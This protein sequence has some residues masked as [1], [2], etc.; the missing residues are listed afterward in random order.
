MKKRVL[1]DDRWEVQWHSQQQHQ[2]V[3]T[4]SKLIGTLFV[5]LRPDR[6]KVAAVAFLAVGANGYEW[7]LMY[8]PP[9]KSHA[10][11]S[12][13][14]H[15]E[16]NEDTD[17]Y[18]GQQHTHT[19]TQIYMIIHVRAFFSNTPLR[20]DIFYHLGTFMTPY[21]LHSFSNTC[22]LWGMKCCRRAE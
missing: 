14:S 12:A 2:N 11:H 16:I 5:A 9:N 6:T 4:S 1:F 18:L 10:Q 20:N 8:T 13:P 7:A 17:I 22:I 21:S 3:T 15:T 19:H